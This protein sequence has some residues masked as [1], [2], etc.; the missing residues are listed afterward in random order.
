MTITRETLELAA[1]AA[2]Y[3]IDATMQTDSG[4]LC[5]VGSEDDWM[6]HTDIGDAARLAVRLRML[7]D[8]SSRDVRVVG[9]M[10]SKSQRHDG[11]YPGAERACC[12]AV[13]LCAAE[14]GWKMN[15]NQA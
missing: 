5:I 13:T 10:K 9:P 2:G 14:I 8:V 11:T 15:G 12:E 7:V 6:P 1:L 4:G 3:V